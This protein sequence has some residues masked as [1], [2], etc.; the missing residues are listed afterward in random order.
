MKIKISILDDCV[1]LLRRQNGKI[2]TCDCPLGLRNFKAGYKKT[3]AGLTML[4]GILSST[5]PCMAEL[6]I[7][8]QNVVPDVSTT[9]RTGNICPY[10]KTLLL[11]IGEEW[12]PSSERPGDV[13]VAL[14]LFKTNSTPK[15]KIL[16]SSG[17]DKIDK[18]AMK[19]A[20]AGGNNAKLPDWFKGESLELLFALAYPG[21]SSEATI[22]A[23]QKVI[24]LPSCS[25]SLEKESTEK[26]S[27]R[28]GV[29]TSP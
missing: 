19:A 12:I 6:G 24:I 26:K 17:N 14:T 27:H 4:I 8:I 16:E 7:D 9:R 2:T 23:K 5:L 20:I 3:A 28:N 1:I 18:S 29:P 10:K 15:C 25:Q 21:G 22:Q 13:V 11:S